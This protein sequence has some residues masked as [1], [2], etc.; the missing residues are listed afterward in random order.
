MKILLLSLSILSIIL[1]SNYNIIHAQNYQKKVIL[2]QINIESLNIL[3]SPTSS[4]SDSNVTF[5]GRWPYGQCHC[6]DVSG[7]ITCFGNGSSMMIADFSNPSSPIELGN[8][9]LI[10][11]QL[12]KRNYHK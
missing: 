5:I 6:V 12:H 4:R 7:N 11:H 2:D 9:L 3:F 10:L 8:V 1:L